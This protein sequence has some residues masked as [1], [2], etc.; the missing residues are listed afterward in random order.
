MV[1]RICALEEIY[2]IGGGESIKLNSFI[3]IIENLCGK[4]ILKNYVSKQKGDVVSTNA[5]C[6]KIFKKTNYMPSTDI[7]TGLSKFHEW[8]K[9]F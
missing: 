3:S 7:K 4:T 1:Q 5:D 2:N 6:T 8:Y 9:N